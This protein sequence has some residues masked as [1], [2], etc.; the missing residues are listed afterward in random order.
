MLFALGTGGNEVFNTTT[1]HYYEVVSDSVTWKTPKGAAED[2]SHLWLEGYLATI[3]S[4]QEDD[5]QNRFTSEAWIGASDA[6]TEDETG[7]GCDA[8]H[9]RRCAQRQR[10]RIG[11]LDIQRRRWTQPDSSR[12]QRHPDAE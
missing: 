12:R 6:D 10:R 5:I 8:H 3:T 2:R 4:Q 1:G 7:R 11:Q 9:Q